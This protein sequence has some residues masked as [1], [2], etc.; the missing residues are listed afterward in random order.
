MFFGIVI[1]AT[2]AAQPYRTATLNYFEAGSLVVVFLTL[3]AGL[4]FNEA[5]FG[6][7]G[8]NALVVF[9]WVLHCAFV[10][11]L[12]FTIAHR[13]ALET[14]RTDSNRCTTAIVRCGALCQRC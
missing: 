6:S 13:L 4:F 10:L 11:A 8:K 12:V 2:I 5:A 9:L 7:G 1:C 3:A 14:K